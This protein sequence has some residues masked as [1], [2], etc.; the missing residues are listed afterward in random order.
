MEDEEE[1]ISNEGLYD[2][3]ASILFDRR[4][5]IADTAPLTKFTGF[6]GGLHVFIVRPGP[7]RDSN[8]SDFRLQIDDTFQEGDVIRLYHEGVLLHQ[9]E[10]HIAEE[11]PKDR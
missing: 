5:R 1:V 2:N 11:H 7:F 4:D 6:E 10:L 3:E 8:E 9:L